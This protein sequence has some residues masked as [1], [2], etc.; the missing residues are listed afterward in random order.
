MSIPI[1]KR[2]LLRGLTGHVKRVALVWLSQYT[3]IDI[4]IIN[5]IDRIFETK[6]YFSLRAHLEE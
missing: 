4:R 5:I 1:S 3:K 2:L 6:G